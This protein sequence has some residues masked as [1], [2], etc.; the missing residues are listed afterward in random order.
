VVPVHLVSA[1]KQIG[2]PFYNQVPKFFFGR[3]LGGSRVE[4][5]GCNN[6]SN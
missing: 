1:E 2:N 3:S 6:N 4:K 5:T